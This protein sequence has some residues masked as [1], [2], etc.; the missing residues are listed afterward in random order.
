MK[1]LNIGCGSNY[2]HAWINIDLVPKS[3]DVKAMDILNGLSYNDNEFDVCYSSHLIEHLDGD[4]LIFFLSE[5]FRVLKSGGILRLVTPD[6]EKTANEYLSIL[7]EIKNGNQ[8]LDSEYEW[9]LLELFD[10]MVRTS[11]GGK[12]GSYIR[13]A[14]EEKRGYIKSRIGAEADAFW[15]LS[16]EKSKRLK[17]FNKLEFPLIIYKLKHYFMFFIVWI[18]FGKKTLKNFKIAIFRGRG[19][20]HQQFFDG[21]SLKKLIESTGFKNFEICTSANST[22]PNFSDFNLDSKNSFT[23]KPDSIFI[24]A[25]KP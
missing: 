20:I 1:M 22:I 18:F 23:K 16:N 8:S 5:C 21:Y 17:F 3:L 10:Q 15:I 13:N 14:R 11:P 12:M 7:A 4:Q 2:H 9:I 24:E 25:I 19:E 6:L